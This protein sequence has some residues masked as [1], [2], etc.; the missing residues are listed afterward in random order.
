MHE[1]LNAAGLAFASRGKVRKF[2]CILWTSQTKDGVDGLHRVIL[3]PL[4]QSKG[5]RDRVFYR[6]DDGVGYF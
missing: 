6:A 3:L 4:R 2:M 1:L 5:A